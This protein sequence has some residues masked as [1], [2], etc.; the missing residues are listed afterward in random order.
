[1]YGTGKSRSDTDKSEEQRLNKIY[2]DLAVSP[3]TSLITLS[4]M[5]LSPILTIR[6]I[7]IVITESNTELP[8]WQ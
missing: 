7:L 6:C 2:S 8:H 3:A 4:F 1:M 5:N